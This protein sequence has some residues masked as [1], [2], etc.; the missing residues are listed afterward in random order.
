MKHV[1]LDTDLG[2]DADDIFALLF[3]IHSPELKIDLIVTSDEHN[4]HR[5]RYTEEFLELIHADIPVVAGLD[6]GNTKLFVVDEQI[7]DKQRVVNNNFLEEIKK[8]IE[9]NELTHY[10][11]IGP[12]SNLAAFIKKYP[13]LKS[14]ITILFMG[15]AINYRVP[16]SP[17]H[18][19]K[20][21]VQSAI[22]VFHSDW[23]KKY[24]LSDVTFKEEIK[25][26]KKSKMFKELEE[27]DKPHLNFIIESMNL[28]F[29]KV[30]PETY[31]H[32]P[33]TL[34]YLID[35]QIINFERQKLKMSK[36]G[37]MQISPNGQETI[38]STSANYE[39]FLRIFKE[40]I[41]K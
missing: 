22:D 6:V 9:K 36:R 28:L 41:L 20:Y 17:E 15:G 30:T 8:V 38:V 3:A 23:N 12:Q 25:I 2:G 32:D 34:S 24:V 39:A 7:K 10:V 1:I 33:I 13:E 31:M 21:D 26:D 29:K 14:K 19:V 18:N 5:A 35:N 27:L 11:C 37:I 4:S 40:R 16:N